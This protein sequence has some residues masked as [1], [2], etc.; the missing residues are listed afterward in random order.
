[1]STGWAQAAC[2]AGLTCFS[3]EECLLEVGEVTVCAQNHLVVVS[4]V[5][6]QMSPASGRQREV[7]HVLPSR[8]PLPRLQVTGGQR[9]PRTLMSLRLG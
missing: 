9:S 8:L 2:E 4:D 3:A 5:L 6:G 1:M 7:R